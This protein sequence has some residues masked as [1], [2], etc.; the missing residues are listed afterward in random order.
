MLKRGFVTVATGK[1]Y[2]WLAESLIMS[3]RLFSDTKYPMYVITDREGEKRLKKLFDG[4]IVMEK[5]T[6]SFLD[7]IR[8]YDNTVFEE[9]IETDGR[10]IQIFEAE[11]YPN[12]Q[13]KNVY[14]EIE[15]TGATWVIKKVY[16]SG[17]LTHKILYT[18]MDLKE[19]QGLP[20]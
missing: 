10:T 16:D 6:Y 1:Y 2:C 13:W 15:V 8:V 7:K 19:I 12:E 14:Q 11:D 20:K 9:T 18:D 17:N 5:P 3:Y 4:V